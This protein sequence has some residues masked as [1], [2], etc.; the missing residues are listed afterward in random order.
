[1]HVRYNP[2]THVVH[3]LC[4]LY[5]R[6]AHVCTRLYMSAHDCKLLCGAL[7]PSVA[8]YKYARPCS[9]LY[10]SLQVHATACTP[11]TPGLD[12]RYT[13]FTHVV[14][15]QHI[16]DTPLAHMLYNIVQFC[17]RL[18][19]CVRSC[20]TMS[21]QI[22]TCTRLHTCVNKPAHVCLHRVYPCEILSRG[23]RGSFDF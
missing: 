5:A 9:I 3:I 4:T 14:Q 11:S 1:M 16:F 20:A 19:T 17:L 2:C 6:I 22:Q 15:A 10:N 23:V 7:Q 12:T 18:S 8:L 21:T 13:W